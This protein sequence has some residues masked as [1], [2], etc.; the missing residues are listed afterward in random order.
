M[1]RRLSERQLEHL[2]HELVNQPLPGEGAAPDLA[3]RICQ[4]IRQVRRRTQRV[5]MALS[6]AL[7]LVGVALLAP[8]AGLLAA[9]LPL[10]ENGLLAL[11]QAARL[12][13]SQGGSYLAD[14][15]QALLSYQVRLQPASAPAAPGLIL[16]A[17]SAILVMD[18]LI[19]REVLE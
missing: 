9:D 19:P 6:A 14:G 15:L 1:R 3:P 16:L 8:S 17:L 5:R 12:L 10:P 7:A 13:F 18:L 4:T 2:L 11:W